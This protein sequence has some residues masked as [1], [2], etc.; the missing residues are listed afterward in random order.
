MR[1]LVN[2]WRTAWA[3]P[4]APFYFVQL[5]P[6]LYTRRKQPKLLSADA[7]PLFWE[8]QAKALSIPH[9]GMAVITDT[10]DALGDI[11]PV[12]KRDVG[13]RLARLA[14][15]RTYQ[16]NIVDSGPVLKEFKI[17]RWE[18]RLEI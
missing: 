9:T 1:A 6:Y 10:V 16:K 3:A 18:R 14:L 12:N 5:A 8:A 11:H 15:A 2:G 4:D 7:L 13:L 17:L